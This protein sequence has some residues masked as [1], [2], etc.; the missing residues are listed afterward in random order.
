[1]W[2]GSFSV[3][4]SK[5][6]KIFNLIG[7]TSARKKIAAVTGKLVVFTAKHLAEKKQVNVRRSLNQ[8]N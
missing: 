4:N 5:A 1:M 3:E 6:F 8:L 7:I 2:L